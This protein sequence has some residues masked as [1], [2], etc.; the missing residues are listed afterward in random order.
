[1]HG[2]RR[3]ADIYA[4]IAGIDLVRAGAGRVLR[5]GGQPAR[6]LRRVVHAREPQDDRCGCSRRCSA[7]Q[8]RRRRWRTTPTCCWTTLRERRAA[9]ASPIPPW[10]CSRP[11]MYNSA[12]FEHAFLAQQMGVELVEGR[13]C[14][15]RTSTVYMR[16]TQGPQRV[17]VIYRRV[18]DDFL[19]PLVVPPRFGAGR[20]RAC[21]RPTAPATSTIWQ[22]HRHRRGR[23]QVDLPL[24]ARHDP[25]LPGRGSRSSTTCPPTCAATPDDLQHV[26]DQPARPRGQGNARRG[27]L[28]HAGRAG[29]RRAPRSTQFREGGR[30]PARRSTSPSRRW[31]CRRARPTSESG[32]APRHIDLRPFVLSGKE[33]RMV[34]GGLTP[35]GAARRARWW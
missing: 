34:P 28:R 35:R 23:R 11:G 25:L 3:A 29:R 9:R 1:M 7:L 19:D 13:T 32:I 17:D 20:C 4:H 18:D 5:A 14:S 6:A 30:S 24:R 22:R 21:C 12:Y 31:R 8:P 27:R 33:V 16:T 10:W 15:S 2:H 26:L